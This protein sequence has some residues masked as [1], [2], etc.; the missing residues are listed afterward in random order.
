MFDLLN[1]Y[2][3]VK[4][5]LKHDFSSL[6]FL[7]CGA[8]SVVLVSRYF[9]LESLELSGLFDLPPRHSSHLQIILS[10]PIKLRFEDC[11]IVHNLNVCSISS[12]PSIRAY[13]ENT[14]EGEC[15]M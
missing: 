13:K 14:E 15:T 3:S 4:L 7:L 1:L 2:K 10:P 12:S 11:C 8:V 9:I 5:K 6:T